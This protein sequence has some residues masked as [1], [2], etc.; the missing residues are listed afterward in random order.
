MA[1]FKKITMYVADLD[2]NLSVEGLQ[3][4]IDSYVLDRIGTNGFCK[5]FEQ[6]SVTQ[7]WYDEHPLN[8]SDNNAN[9]AEWERV[10]NTK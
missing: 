3:D 6:K 5:L 1:T 4:M 2:E 7:E 8:Y 10:L 9:P